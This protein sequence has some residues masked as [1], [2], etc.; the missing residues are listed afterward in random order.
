MLTRLNQIYHQFL[1]NQ[2]VLL[3]GTQLQ[4]KKVTWPNAV[5]GEF[6]ERLDYL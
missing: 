2:K 6:W 3:Q 5:K 4:H 1:R